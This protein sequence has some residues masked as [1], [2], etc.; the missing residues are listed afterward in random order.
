MTNKKLNILL[1]AYYFAPDKIV[2][3][4]RAS[5][6]YKNLP[7]AIDCEV[8]V[9]TAN[10][11]PE[12]DKVYTVPTQKR[13]LKSMLIKDPGVLWTN[14]VK[15]FL[16]NRADI[17]P[18]IVIITGGPFM[19]FTLTGWFKRRYNCKVILD[20]RDPF[21]TNPGFNNGKIV[22]TVK[23]FFEKRFNRNADALVTVNEYCSTII[24]NF[25]D[26]KNAIIQNGFDETVQVEYVKPRLSGPVQLV[27]TGKFYFDP[28][29]LVEAI[30]GTSFNL[31][32][33]GGDGNRLNTEYDNVQSLGLVP[34]AESVRAIAQSDVGVI[35]TYGEDFQSTTKLFDYIRCKRP[36]L[37]ISDKYLNRGSIADE[38]ALY[39]NVFWSRNEESE[40]RNTLKK[41]GNHNYIEPDDDFV[42]KFSRRRQMEKLV[43]LINELYE[44][45]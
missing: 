39:P 44:T 20:Y 21:A 15:S 33:Y 32:Y 35:Q 2:G 11:H 4:L 10:P 3:A 41:I 34:Y 18:D 43:T 42:N 45:I 26:K 36:I 24:E 37:I 6:W 12:G 5:Y 7:N 9:L 19:H 30:Q 13:N 38:L 16:K 23:K 1:L 25:K 28:G 27:Y 8:T 29:K 22:R 17:N 14:N 31:K 40:I